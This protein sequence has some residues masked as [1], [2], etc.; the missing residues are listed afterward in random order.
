ME[1]KDVFL[2]EMRD[3]C[4]RYNIKIIDSN[5]DDYNNDIDFSMKDIM[6]E[7]YIDIISKK[8]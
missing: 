1:N 8:K 7:P 6:N 4:K 3:L 5:N 2:K